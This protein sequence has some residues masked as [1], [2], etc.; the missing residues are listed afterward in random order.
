MVAFFLFLI[1]SNLPQWMLQDPSGATN[2]YVP[3]E[4]KEDNMDGNL[5]ESLSETINLARKTDSV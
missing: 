3:I 5:Q 2:I 1:H 4:T